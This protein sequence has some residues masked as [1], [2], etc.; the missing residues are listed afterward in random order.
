MPLH[1][2]YTIVQK[3]PKWPKTQIK[4]GGPAL[5]TMFYLCHLQSTALSA[6]EKTRWGIIGDFLMEFNRIFMSWRLKGQYFL[7]H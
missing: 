4:G 1:L 7:G 2:F 6:I 3:S 5:I